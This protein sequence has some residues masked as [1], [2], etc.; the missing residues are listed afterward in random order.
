MDMIKFFNEMER[1]TTFQFTLLGIL[2]IYP[3][4]CSL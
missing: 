3:F 2:G 1:M 4:R